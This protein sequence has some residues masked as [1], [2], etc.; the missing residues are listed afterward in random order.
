MREILQQ[1]SDANDDHKLAPTCQHLPPPQRPKDLC[2]AL[3]LSADVQTAV[4]QIRGTQILRNSKS[5]KLFPVRAKPDFH[6]ASSAV[7][8][9]QCNGLQTRGRAPPPTATAI[10]GPRSCRGKSHESCGDCRV[11]HHQRLR[12]LAGC[13][14][15]WSH[16]LHGLWPKNLCWQVEDHLALISRDCGRPFRMPQ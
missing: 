2:P 10:A 15:S 5:E 12:V 9:W 16:G 3:V 6:K 13:S 8:R 4:S 1:C 11:C 7:L 14:N